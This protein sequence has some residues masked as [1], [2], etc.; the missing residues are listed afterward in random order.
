VKEA[1]FTC[2]HTRNLNE[3]PLEN[4]SGAIR[5]CCGFN[6]NSAVGQFVDALK[7]NIISGLAYRGLCGTNCEDE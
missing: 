4:T 6:N 5:S 7:A 3:D 2:L 1:G